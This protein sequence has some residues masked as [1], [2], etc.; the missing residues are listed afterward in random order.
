ME[1]NQTASYS[2][3]CP[4]NPFLLKNLDLHHNHHNQSPW[5][6]CPLTEWNIETVLPADLVSHGLPSA[7]QTSLV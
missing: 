4:C 6:E 3:I 2:L 1:S 7:D 5:L